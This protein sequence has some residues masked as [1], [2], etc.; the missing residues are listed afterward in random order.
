MTS[1]TL[2]A[3]VAPSEPLEPRDAV[4]E[5]ALSL[6]QPLQPQLAAFQQALRPAAE[7]NV[8]VTG[9]PFRFRCRIHSSDIPVIAD[10]FVGL[11]HVPP[12]ALPERPVIVDLGANIGCTMVHYAALYPGARIVGVELDPE[13]ARLARLNTAAIAAQTTLLHAAIWPHDGTVGYGGD[14]AWGYRV[15]A[16]GERAVEALS[17]PSLTRRCGL[18]TIDFLKVDIE[19]AERDLFQGSLS[20]LKRVRALAIEVHDDEALIARLITLLTRHGFVAQRD[21]HHWSAVIAARIRG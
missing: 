15:E 16:G 10:T 17:M 18:S 4:P 20:W 13:N 3:S 12:V 11:Y 5:I 7:V 8:L 19:G 1:D 2:S 9:T 6:E 14:E 21:T